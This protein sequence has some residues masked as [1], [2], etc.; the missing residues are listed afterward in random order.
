MANSIPLSKDFNVTTNT[1]SPAGTALYANGLM[2][3]TSTS[4]PSATI[5]YAYQK[6]D[7]TT[8]F[9]AGSD[10]ETCADV[11][12]GGFDNASVLPGTLLIVGIPA[13]S[14]SGGLYSG[15]LASVTMA[16]INA[17]AAGT[18]TLDVDGV[19]QTSSSID[20]TTAGTQSEVA[21]IIQAALTGVTVTW[22]STV[23]QLVIK[24]NTTGATSSVGYASGDI[25]TTLLLTEAG[26]ATLGVGTTG[27]TLTELMDSVVDQS[28]NWVAFASAQKLTDAQQTELCVWNTAQANRYVYAF[29]DNSTAATT[30]SSNT[31]FYPTVVTANSYTG[32]MGVYG[33]PEYAFT[34]LS[35]CAAIDFSATN[36]R[37]T[38]KF[39]AFDGLSTNVTSLSAAKA[40]ESN[41]YSYYGYYSQNSTVKNYV[42]PGNIS[43]DF[44][45]LE[46]YVDQ[47]WIKAN[48]IAAFANQFT[49]NQSYAFNATGYASIQAAVLDPMTSALAFGAVKKGVSLDSSETTQIKN[50]VGKD[51]TQQLYA[52]GWYLYIPTQSGSNRVARKLTGAV[53]YYVDGQMIQSINLT[54]TAVL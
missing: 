3:T 43:G 31:A 22:N 1:I 24:S 12:F 10:E 40:L 16:T 50:S 32:I 13:A 27:M 35:F 8:L 14:T 45:W 52:D 2:L 26:G 37:L 15:S 33:T 51:I 53:L 28:Q 41:G 5:Q 23:S 42:G 9:G 20:L 54:S 30:A 49:A 36:G 25:A 29:S 4:I 48:L 11:Y 39:R 19:S 6:S 44:D 7:V 47:I 46:S 17:L 18:I 21:S 38:Y 34:V